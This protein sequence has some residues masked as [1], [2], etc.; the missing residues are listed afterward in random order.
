MVFFVEPGTELVFYNDI[1]VVGLQFDVMSVE[2]KIV[3]TDGVL[4]LA[5]GGFG[6]DETNPHREFNGFWDEEV[7]GLCEQAIILLSGGA[8]WVDLL[9]KTCR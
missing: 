3:E 7:T 8:I 2:G 5:I 1:G 9:Q 6:I 4:G